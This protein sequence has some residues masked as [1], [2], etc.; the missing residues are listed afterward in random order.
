MDAKRFAASPVGRLVPV[1]GYD[2]RHREEYD[3][4]AFVPDPLPDSL[5]LAATTYS[6]ATQAQA[7]VAR[8]DQ[9]TALLPNPRLL[10][11]PST[12]LEAVSTSAL[13]GT[14][15]AF[16]DVLAADLLG[17]KDAS[18]SVA[19][20]LNYVRA[21]EHGYAWVRE[22]P[23]TLGLLCDL[24]AMLVRGT[25]GGRTGAGALRET[26]VVIGAPGGRI[27]DARFVPPPPGDLLR[28]G[29]EAWLAW[30]GTDGPM[31]LLVRVAVAHYQFESLH[32]F[33]DG[34][35]RLGRLVAILQ[36]ISAGELRMPVVNISP[37]LV[38]RRDD[39]QNLLAH[40]SATGDWDSWVSFFAEA[41]LAGAGDAV[42][43][44]ER[45][46]DLRDRLVG[47]VRQAGVRGVALT[48]AEELI[49]YPL[50]TSRR[51]AEST[52]VSYPAANA[53]IAR[54]VEL[55]ILRERTGRAYARV[56]ACDEVLEIIER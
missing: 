15:A 56:F 12:T 49:G 41:V 4:V 39:Y 31:P 34:N 22:R 47:R 2:V 32:P 18:P 24:Q 43:T 28:D 44:I 23:M 42:S 33:T 29:L 19:E 55:G 1:R 45:L 10:I 6:L 14:Y 38:S 35:G 46:L 36:L 27:A 50:I 20:V 25:P 48:I 8:A 9:A 5:P 26:V 30:V 40:V 51:A 21:A 3:H 16:T 53:G 52:G 17:D 13:E 54:L 37:W 7:A 11:R